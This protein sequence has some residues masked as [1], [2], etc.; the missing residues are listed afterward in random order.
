[1]VGRYFLGLGEREMIVRGAVPAVDGR[2]ALIWA[3]V[4]VPGWN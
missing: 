1:M 2:V 3:A 4:V